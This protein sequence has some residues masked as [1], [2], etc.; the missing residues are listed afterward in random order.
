MF[1]SIHLNSLVWH[2]WNVILTKLY[3]SFADKAVD[4]RTNT[5]VAL[6]QVR[7][8]EDRDNGFP[9]T[10]L[11]EIRLL[12]SIS[13]PHI[14]SLLEVAVGP[15]QDEIYLVFEY[16]DH[17]M[18]ELLDSPM[19]KSKPFTSS[20]VKCLLSQ[21]LQAVAHLHSHWMIHRDIKMSN[22]LY[23]NRGVL[24]L[25]DFGLARHFTCAASAERMT[26]RVVTLWYRAP[27]LLLFG[28]SEY[29]T[30]VDMWSCGCILAELLLGHPLLPGDNELDQVARMFRL[31][32]APNDKIWPGY[33]QKVSNMALNIIAQPYNNLRYDFDGIA[34][35][36][37][38]GSFFFF[39]FFGLV[40]RRLFLTFL[41]V[42]Q[43][44]VSRFE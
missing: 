11:R 43:S 41:P 36:I 15:K 8:E 3:F 24:K 30:A 42:S 19:I 40:K 23:S 35:I 1:F 34:P 14:V 33:S 6:K 17:D 10:A 22:L 2:L 5:I 9:I 38:F 20:E 31:L 37:F 4:S 7:V 28:N 21:L 18:A 13:H 32:G 12:A 39:F 27:E 16:I 44:H 25:A 26:P 29:D